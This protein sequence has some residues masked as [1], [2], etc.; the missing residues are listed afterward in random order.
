MFKQGNAGRYIIYAIG[1]IVLVV[2]GPAVQRD[3][4]LYKSTNGMSGGRNERE[5]IA[6]ERK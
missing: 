6:N 3:Q 5:I 2:I 4:L 1:E